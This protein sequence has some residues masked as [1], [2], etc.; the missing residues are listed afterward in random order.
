QIRGDPS[1]YRRAES[2][3]GRFACPDQKPCGYKNGNQPYQCPQCEAGN[4]EVVHDLA[5][6]QRG[7]EFRQDREQDY[8]KQGHQPGTMWGQFPQE[9]AKRG[10]ALDTA[11]AH[12]IFLGQE[13]LTCLAT[14][15]LG[16]LRQ[17]ELSRTEKGFDG[18]RNC[19]ELRQVRIREVCCCE[20]TIA[21]SKN[22]TAA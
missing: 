22:E 13:S 5:N 21:V 18:G 11:R 20:S 3:L 7:G 10:P 15:P 6:D 4:H 14:N 9:T 12:A 17:A 8:A 2:T 19:C 1:P 16:D